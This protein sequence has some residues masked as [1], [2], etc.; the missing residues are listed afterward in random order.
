MSYPMLPAPLSLATNHLPV[1]P[2]A[3]DGQN[4]ESGWLLEA[5]ILRA[6]IGVYFK[7]DDTVDYLHNFRGIYLTSPDNADQR[8]VP[9]ESASLCW[10]LHALNV[11]LC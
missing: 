10:S 8:Y 9:S 11:L 4:P 5:N 6:F 2:V 3:W 1:W 7:L